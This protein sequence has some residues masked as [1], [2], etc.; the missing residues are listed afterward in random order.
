VVVELVKLGEVFEMEGEGE[1]GSGSGVGGGR[2]GDATRRPAFGR[3][4]G[5]ARVLTGPVSMVSL[6]Q[7]LYNDCWCVGSNYSTKAL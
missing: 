5:R 1:G 7:L 3:A 6:F 2:G 4:R